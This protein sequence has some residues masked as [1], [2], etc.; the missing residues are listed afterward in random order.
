MKAYLLQPEVIATLIILI[1]AFSIHRSIIWSAGKLSKKV[2]R[3]KLRKQYLNR[4]VGYVIWT[5]AMISIILVWGLKRDGFWVALGSTFAV[6][7]V[8][9]FANWSILSNVT[10]SFILYFTFPYKIGDRVRIHDKDLPVTAV[11]EDIKGFYT[12]LRT[13]EGELITYPNNLLL[14][15]GVSI[16]YNREE[17][18]FDIDK[19]EETDPTAR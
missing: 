12:I 11:I 16:L 8:A 15:K 13:A 4:Y 3:S 10:A 14:Q 19:H 18:I 2:E 6:V 9:L 1:V 7:G 5:M 17:S